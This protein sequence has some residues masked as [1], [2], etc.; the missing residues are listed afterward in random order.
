MADAPEDT[1]LSLPGPFKGVVL[2][3]SAEGALTV[4]VSGVEAGADIT[5]VVGGDVKLKAQTPEHIARYRR[6]LEAA[7]SPVVL[8]QEPVMPEP[9][10]PVVPVGTLVEG[11][12][13]YVGPWAP[14]DQQKR[15]LGR[16]FD[17]YAA[18][19]DFKSGRG[20][21]S[22]TYNEAVQRVAGLKNFHG[23]DGGH[24]E[25]EAAI[26]DA[27]L[28]DPAALGKW[29]IPTQSMLNGHIEGQ[30]AKNLFNLYAACEQGAF[31][32][33]FVRKVA[34]YGTYQ[35]WSSTTSTDS[36]VTCI[37]IFTGGGSRKILKDNQK[38]L[39]STRVVRAE[40]RPS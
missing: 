5:L 16:V 40:L 19:E 24:F 32:G 35:Y 9:P 34:P 7:S 39:A 37:G 20:N 8:H 1:I 2:M 18:P 28:S 6:L 27:A 22:T 36:G 38:Y 3:R 30:K 26:L 15:A 11:K 10:K 31:K 4:D 29:F 13:V 33:T 23:H 17:L 25:T 12:G 14:M 21:L